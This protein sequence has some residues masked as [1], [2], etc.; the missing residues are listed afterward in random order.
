MRVGVFSREA[1]RTRA[2][3][4][5]VVAEA[6]AVERQ[7]FDFLTYPQ[8]FGFD[9]MTLATVVGRETTRIELATG[10]VPSPLRHPAALAQQARTV[11]AAVS[12]RFTLGIGL[13][14]AIVTEGMFGL[15]Y[16][17]PARRMRETLEVLAPLLRGEAVDF[18]GDFQTMRGDVRV[19]G[20]EPVPLLVAALGP[21]MLEITGRLADGTSTWMT[22]PATL[23]SHVVPTI[24]EAAE[25]AGRPAPRIVA[26]LPTALVSDTAAARE[27]AC[28]DFA[29]YD[30]LP[31][32]RAMLDREG[33]D[34]RPGDIAVLGDEAALRREIDRLRDAGATDF[35]AV[36]FPADPDAVERTRAFLAA[37]YCA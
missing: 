2:T 36:A 24:R 5:D 9:A 32:Y 12:G 4:E 37:E 25:R 10:V 20:A 11:Q 35:C 21:R 13:S 34:T 28:A 3:I 29:V 18:A 19:A 6:V 31:S 15:P 7:G 27:K 16:A 8:L 1:A 33:A 26:S 22:G 23:A 14:H 30:T 17:H